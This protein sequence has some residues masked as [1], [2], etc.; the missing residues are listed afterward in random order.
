MTRT[1]DQI[2]SGEARVNLHYLGQKKV[3]DRLD[4]LMNRL[5]IVIM[6]ASLVLSSSIL[7]VGR[8]DR[9]IYKLGVG[10]WLLAVVVAI[11]LVISA[12]HKGWKNRG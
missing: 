9:F 12:L 2:A 5:L 6:L 1:L 8:R 3:F 7:V 4:Q 11:I 10:G